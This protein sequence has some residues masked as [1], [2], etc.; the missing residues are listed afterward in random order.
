MAAVVGRGELVIVALIA[1]GFL[2]HLTV[3]SR[4]EHNAAQVRLYARFRDQLAN[5]VAP[6]GQVSDSGRL[7]ANGTPMAL[8]EIPR[9]HLREVV[10]EA[11]TSAVLTQGP[12]HQRN[13]P[14]PGQPGTS[15]VDGRAA[16]YGGPFGGLRELKAGDP[17]TVTTGEG[18]AHFKVVDIRDDGGPGAPPLPAGTARLTLV[19]AR[20]LPFMPVGVTRV[21]AD[22]VGTPLAASP[23]PVTTVPRSELPLGTQTDSLYALVLWLEALVVVAVL[24]IWSWRRWSPVRTWIIGFPVGAL[25]LYYVFGQVVRLFPN[26]L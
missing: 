25:V 5:G 24:G 18:T 3:I 11:T 22:L 20:G 6:L 8:L 7:L 4:F 19:T 10:S 16:A 2:A 21:D 1:L 13:T 12:G 26:L 14:F 23:M 9:L 15:V 17:I